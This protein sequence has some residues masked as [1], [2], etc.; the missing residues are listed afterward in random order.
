M[1]ERILFVVRDRV[2]REH[3]AQ[4]FRRRG[5]SAVTASDGVGGLFQF[6]LCQPHLIILDLRGWEV[7]Q[8]IRAL[9]EIPIIVLV[10]D[11]PEA[12]IESLN[13]GAD[14]FVVKPPSVSELEARVRA[15]LRRGPG[16]KSGGAALQGRAQPM[17]DV[18]TSQEGLMDGRCCC[19]SR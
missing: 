4:A 2:M 16:M 5:F 18:G 14:F 3:L 19:Q 1:E 13:Q 6:G 11:T 17:A 10:E 9:S 12:R 8:R 15:L 7:L